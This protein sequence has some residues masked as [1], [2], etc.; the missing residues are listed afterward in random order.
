MSQVKF[1]SWRYHQ[2]QINGERITTNVSFKYFLMTNPNPMEVRLL[3]N[4]FIIKKRKKAILSK[5]CITKVIFNY[6]SAVKPQILMKH[7]RW[8]V[9]VFSADKIVQNDAVQFEWGHSFEI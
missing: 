4:Y 7:S 2:I 8:L 9:A 6:I 5:Y 1:G 3:I